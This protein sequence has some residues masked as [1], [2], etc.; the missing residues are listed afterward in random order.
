MI[1]VIALT[2]DRW[3]PLWTSR[4]HI[5]TRLAT[6]FR[7]QWIEPPHEW[8][9]AARTARERSRES[10][11][12]DPAPLV[13]RRAELW[14]PH[15]YRPR[16]LATRVNALRMA[17]A[18]T[19]LL[20]QG[21]TRVVLYAWHY[22]CLPDVRA[23]P[24]DLIVYHIVDEYSYA[25]TEHAIEPAERELIARADRVI[26]HS[27]ALM[28]KKGHINPATVMIPNGVDYHAFAHRRA[29]PADLVPIPHPRVGYAGFIKKQLDWHLMYR[30]ARRHPEWSWVFVGAR[31][32]HSEITEALHDLAQ[33]SNVFFLG[34]KPA[35]MLASYPQHFDV[36]IM[37]YRSID[38]T[39]YIYPL[40]LHEYLA[41][42]QPIVAT[43]INAL[44]A[45]AHVVALVDSED[46]WSAAIAA[47]MTPAMHAAAER[48]RRQAVARQHDWDTLVGRVAAVI[49]DGLRDVAV[50]R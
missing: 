9:D 29:E 37:P 1:G 14:L 45:F 21:C 8:R 27:P 3:G 32:A 40:K 11:T 49:E 24:H 44:E 17:R 4:H 28:A 22:D 48:D 20:A 19:A 31:H 23:V 30:L 35:S 6:R 33:L 15:L 42:G 13:V 25:E 41:A 16:W 43:R 39:K 34:P 12:P 5:L 38:Y 46:S 7:V 18:R 36:S 10:Q 50:P 47:G 2:N 26:V